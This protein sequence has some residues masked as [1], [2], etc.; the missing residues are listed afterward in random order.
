MEAEGRKQSGG[1]R[2]SKRASRSHGFSVL[3]DIG[4]ITARSEDLKETLQRIVEVVAARANA[5]VCSLYILDPRAQ[6]LTLWATQGLTPG[7]VGLYQINVR[8]PSDARAG[9]LSVLIL[10]G[11]AQSNSGVLPVR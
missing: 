1:G 6:R 2:A 4:A 3:E 7:S 5:D 10:Q 11:G 9:D 8:V